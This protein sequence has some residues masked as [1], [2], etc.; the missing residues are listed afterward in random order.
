MISFHVSL[1]HYHDYAD[2]CCFFFFVG[3]PLLYNILKM[4]TV[5]DV[6]RRLLQCNHKILVVPSASKF[7]E[8]DRRGGYNTKIKRTTKQHV[9]EGMKL[10]G[11]E[12]KKW[13]EEWKRKL[14][15]DEVV[16]LQPGDYEV[17][18]KFDKQETIDDWTVTADSDHN[19]GKSK[20][21]FLLGRNRTGIFMG[22]TNIKPPKDGIIKS[23]GYCN[24]RS[25]R[26]MVSECYRCD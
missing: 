15:C 9:K 18:W 14:A 8:P 3:R 23:A 17:L 22:K 24:I 19:E 25:P 10:L 26:N 16:D 2:I 12:L 11:P 21:Q 1:P 4:Q 7:W 20:A 6:S 13:Q 5:K